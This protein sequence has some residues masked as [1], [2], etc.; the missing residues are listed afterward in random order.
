[1]GNGGVLAKHLQAR[2]DPPVNLIGQRWVQIRD[3]QFLYEHPRTGLFRIARREERRLG[4]VLLTGQRRR[5]EAP[6]QAV[7]AAFEQSASIQ[8]R[9][10]AGA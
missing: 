2:G 7:A 9:D 8:G 1:L 5:A 10:P 6:L 4:I 3:R